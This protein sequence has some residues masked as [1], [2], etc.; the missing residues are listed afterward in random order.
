MA[1][2][3]A[4]FR[5]KV[6]VID[7]RNVQMCWHPGPGRTSDQIEEPYEYRQGD[8]SGVGKSAHT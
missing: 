3:V 1:D 4:R 2:F 5:H 8:V 7:L 6:P